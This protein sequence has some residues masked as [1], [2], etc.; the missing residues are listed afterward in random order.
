MSSTKFSSW[1]RYIILLIF[2]AFFFSLTKLNSMVFRST[3]ILTFFLSN[4]SFISLNLVTL[5]MGSKCLNLSLLIYSGCGSGGSSAIFSLT[6]CWIIA[7]KAFIILPPFFGLLLFSDILYFLLDKADLRAA[8]TPTLYF[9]S[10]TSGLG[11][12]SPLGDFDIFQF[13]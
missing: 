10:A 9:G 11:D 6:F 3:N 5:Y 1:L 4:M 8:L 2:P 7:A 12:S 13:S